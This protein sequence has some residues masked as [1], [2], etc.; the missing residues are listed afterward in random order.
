[1]VSRS[2]IKWLAVLIV[3]AVFSC[4]DRNFQLI[5]REDGSI[6]RLN[7]KTGEMFVLEDDSC[8]VVRVDT[9][10]DTL[11]VKSEAL[12]RQKKPLL[13]SKYDRLFRKHKSE[14]YEWETLKFND[15][16]GKRINARA[17]L[18]S[19]IHKGTVQYI[20]RMHIVSKACYKKASHE[21]KV[22]MHGQGGSELLTFPIKAGKRNIVW[23]P[24]G[25]T[26]DICVANAVPCDEETAKQF[27]WW[28]LQWT[29]FERVIKR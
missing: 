9:V 20:F 8:R 7:K 2:Y 18:K 16:K 28:R 21:M 27:A 22:I 13:R 29:W 12:K 24:D 26:I 19:R 25:K 6:V 3:I 10:Y 23:Q 5:E 11:K 15:Q 14:I 17:Y 1:M 4:G